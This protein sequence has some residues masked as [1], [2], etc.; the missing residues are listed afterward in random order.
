MP[1]TNESMKKYWAT[2]SPEERSS[3]CRKAA[4]IRQQKTSKRERKFYSYLMIDAKYKKIKERN[5]L[6][7]LQ[8]EKEKI[9]EDNLLL[10]NV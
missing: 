4:I 8:L 7:A 3:R 2:I 1:F 9:E 5:R 10:K 6:K